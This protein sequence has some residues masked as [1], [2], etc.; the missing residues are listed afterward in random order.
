M[1][2]NNSITTKS[3]NTYQNLGYHPKLN[4]EN[5]VNEKINTIYSSQNPQSNANRSPHISSSPKFNGK[6]NY[7]YQKNRIN[8]NNN[9]YNALII[10]YN[11]RIVAAAKQKNILECRKIL[12]E[13][14]KAGLLPDLYS[15]NPMLNLIV[16]KRP[17]EVPAL[18][19]EIKEAGLKPNLITYTILMQ[20]Y[21][22]NGQ[23]RGALALL[24]EMKEEGIKPR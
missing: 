2:M 20:I 11:K 21:V 4:T 12:N 14:K 24:K 1:N 10:P 19:K 16:K 17:A 13:I 7:S 8:N 9:N 3:S 6:K 15:Y 23:L 22:K 5:E 18:L